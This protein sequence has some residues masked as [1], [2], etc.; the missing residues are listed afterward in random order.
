[1][2]KV[3]TRNEIKKFQEGLFE[4]SRKV[5][6]ASLGVVSTVEEGGKNLF[7]EL[8]EKGKGIEA[9]GRK[10]WSKAKSELETTTDQIGDRLDRSVADVLN[11]M[12]VPSA[13]QVEE[14]T[15]R[16]EKLMTQVDR[17]ASASKSAG[18]KRST[19]RASAAKRTS[20]AA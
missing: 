15:A 12:G 13:G 1:M 18:S 19:T 9:K 3:A 14:L 5:W 16:V 11:R 7:S 2:A 20:K 8:V 10:Q 6:L 17:L 4:S